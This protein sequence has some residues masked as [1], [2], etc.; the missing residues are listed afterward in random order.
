MG[1][2]GEVWKLMLPQEHL[3]TQER[4]FPCIATLLPY[5]ST[6]AAKAQTRASIFRIGSDDL[7]HRSNIGINPEKENW[8]ND[9]YGP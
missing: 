4:A 5:T 8:H 1:C 6:S 7:H 2:N 9:F 3:L